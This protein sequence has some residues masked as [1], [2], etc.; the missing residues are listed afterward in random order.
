MK[1]IIHPILEPTREID[2]TRRVVAAIA[3]E[4]SE[5]YG[6]SEAVN[7]LEAERHVQS[8]FPNEIPVAHLRQS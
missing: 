6:G 4:L 3:K 2:V 7:W 8:L 1:I 5:T